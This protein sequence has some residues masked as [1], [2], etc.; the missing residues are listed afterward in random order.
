MFGG[1]QAPPPVSA[2][3]TIDPS[4]VMVGEPATGTATGTNSNPR[5]LASRRI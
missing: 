3:C 1:E 5:P 4:E 2:S